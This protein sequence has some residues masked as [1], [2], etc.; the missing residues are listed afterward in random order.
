MKTNQRDRSKRIGV[1]L[2]I[3]LTFALALGLLVFGV[4]PVATASSMHFGGGAQ[5]SLRSHAISSTVASHSVVSASV[6]SHRTVAVS[7]AER[8]V[9]IASASS[10]RFLSINR[11]NNPLRDRIA[12][13]NIQRTAQPQQ[14]KLE[15]DK[16][17]ALNTRLDL[18]QRIPVLRPWN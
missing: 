6:A 5:S 12:L 11:V 16:Y 9:T 7:T 4:A 1:K 14:I 3:T 13:P 10:H 18:R 2:A 17:E 15:R 8:S